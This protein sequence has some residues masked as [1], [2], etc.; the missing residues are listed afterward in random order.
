MKILDTDHVEFYVGDALAAARSLCAAYGFRVYG[1]GGPETSLA[2]QR[3]VL[4]GQGAI[5]VLLTSGLHK[6]HPA[7]QFV[8][9]HGDGV[10]VIA[11]RTDSVASAYADVVAAGGTG[12]RQPRSWDSGQA[13]VITADIAGFG[14]VVYRLVERH[15]PDAE[16]QPGAVTMDPAAARDP[17][18]ASDPAAGGGA[19]DDLLRL[20]D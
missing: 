20:I 8:A 14:D 6:D 13:R 3:S 16:F 12:I 2:G 11:M 10:G 9:R 15:G 7:S 5:R 18:A 4:I 17:A 1:N 19:D